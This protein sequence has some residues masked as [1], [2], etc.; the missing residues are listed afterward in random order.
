MLSMLM[1]KSV[2]RLRPASEFL[3]PERAVIE[4]VGE[5]RAKLPVN[6]YGDKIYSCL[7]QQ[8][9]VSHM[10]VLRECANKFVE[11]VRDY[12]LASADLEGTAKQPG[13]FHSVLLIQA[14]GHPQWLIHLSEL[15]KVVG[16]EELCRNLEFLFRVTADPYVTVVG[17]D[18]I[19]DLNELRARMSETIALPDYPVWRNCLPVEDAFMFTRKLGVYTDDV[20]KTIGLKK[21][22]G[23]IGFATVGW[24]HKC[25]GRGE[26]K[27]KIGTSQ[28]WKDLPNIRQL[29]GSHFKM[30]DWEVPRLYP[31]QALYAYMDTAVV[32][33]FLLD[34]LWAA[35]DRHEIDIEDGDNVSSA[36][37]KYF[38]A[39]YAG[40]EQYVEV[41]IRRGR[42]H[43]RGGH[44]A[45]P[46]RRQDWEAVMGKGPEENPADLRET[47]NKRKRGAPDE[48]DEDEPRAP[49]RIQAVTRTPLEILEY[50]AQFRW[51]AALKPHWCDEQRS[52]YPV[53]T[54][55]ISVEFK[56]RIRHHYP[57]RQDGAYKNPRVVQGRMKD[58]NYLAAY[59]YICPTTVCT[60][61][62]GRHKSR[63]PDCSVTQYHEGRTLAAPRIMKVF[64]C[65][66]CNSVFHTTPM[67]GR[68]HAYCQVCQERGHGHAKGCDLSEEAKTLMRQLFEMYRPYGYLTRLAGEDP[69]HLWGRHPDPTRNV[70]GKGEVAP[71]WTEDELADV[72]VDF[73]MP[74]HIHQL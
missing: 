4:S 73:W 44:P 26:F 19:N 35:I 22:L 14:L 24:S 9:H 42:E 1:T 68:L 52:E 66:A 20:E 65:L 43:F 54:R 51:Y 37:R 61:C 18:I 2:P 39:V 10:A 72:P 3:P 40:D 69:Y 46:S 17:S 12:G 53:S 34:S 31:Q 6:R 63:G 5:L 30:Y 38:R 21:G 64:P 27:K 23:A 13:S 55:Y 33:L 8:I 7:D 28:E 74:D 70:E 58:P 36:F 49:K 60:A 25:W 16:R 29:T 67:C 56:Q 32:L 45:A 57:E 62:G 50:H 59:P 15:E 47:L 71:I 48:F 41:E 11:Q